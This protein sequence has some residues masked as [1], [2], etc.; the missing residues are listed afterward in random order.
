MQL[1]PNLGDHV[2][3]IMTQNVQ[4]QDIWCKSNVQLQVYT[5]LI[6]LINHHAIP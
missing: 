3:N 2:T 6:I 4:K 1:L 5:V